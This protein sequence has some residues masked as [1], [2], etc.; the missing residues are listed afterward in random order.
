MERD[1]IQ[2][3]IGA[4]RLLQQKQQSVTETAEK[5]QN[6]R[7][8]TA[9]LGLRAEVGHRRRAE[10]VDDECLFGSVIKTSDIIRL[11]SDFDR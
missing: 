10:A 3:R 1:K 8:V 2:T 4:V 7:D 6:S 11:Q 5:A 9:L